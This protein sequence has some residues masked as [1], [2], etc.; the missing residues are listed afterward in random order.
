MSHNYE[1]SPRVTGSERRCRRLRR[2][3]KNLSHK[4][5]ARR[6]MTLP[7]SPPPTT[8]S[9]RLGTNG[10]D[11]LS[12]AHVPEHRLAQQKLGNTEEGQKPHLVSLCGSELS[13]TETSARA[14]HP[15]FI[16]QGRSKARPE[17]IP[18]L[19]IRAP[20]AIGICI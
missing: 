16:R 15:A 18:L 7:P 8:T 4:I 3:L 5:P 13:G 12:R 14:A 6:K 11:S 2:R 10:E 1:I 20:I 19:C 17:R 9:V